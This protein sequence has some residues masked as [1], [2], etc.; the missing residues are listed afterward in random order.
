VKLYRK[1]GKLAVWLAGNGKRAHVA[2]E[3]S[4]ANFVALFGPV[5]ILD[6]QEPLSLIGAAVGVDPGD[7]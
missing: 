3:R 6:S 7:V 4:L 1:Q 5:I 2:D